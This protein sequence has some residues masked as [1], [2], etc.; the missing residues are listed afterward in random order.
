MQGAI[1]IFKKWREECSKHISFTTENGIPI[2]VSKCDDC[3]AQ[4]F[5]NAIMLNK[6]CQLSDEKIVDFV[7]K[8]SSR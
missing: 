5:C 2:V 4:D 7:K 8:V 3:K 6:P 1:P